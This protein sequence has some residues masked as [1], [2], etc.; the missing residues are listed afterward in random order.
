M[1][2]L[3]MSPSAQSRDLRRTVRSYAA[4]TSADVLIP[5]GVGVLV[6][7]VAVIVLVIG[8]R[9][10]AEDAP[11]PSHADWTSEHVGDVV[12]PPTRTVAD[13]VAA[14]QGDTGPFLVVAPAS[15]AR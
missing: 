2:T 15:R 13:A 4:A 9:R 12:T 6:A 3:R 8:L 11:V 5:V 7:V 14:R 10:R 1:V